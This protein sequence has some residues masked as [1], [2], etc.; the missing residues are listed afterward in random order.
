V[1]AA[2]HRVPLPVRHRL[3]RRQNPVGA[4][5]RHYRGRRAHPTRL[6]PA[7]T[8]QSPSR[9][10]GEHTSAVEAA[11]APSA[12]LRVAAGPVRGSF[13][14]VPCPPKGRASAQTPLP[15]TSSD[16][17]YLNKNLRRAHL[18]TPST[19]R[20][21]GPGRAKTPFDGRRPATGTHSPTAAP[22]PTTATHQLPWPGDQART[23]V[24]GTPES[25][26]GCTYAQAQSTRRRGRASPT[27]TKR[28]CQ[29]S[30]VGRDQ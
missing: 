22:S 10:L 11:C 6:I 19:T 17:Q 25:S 1:A 29:A 24:T 20:S 28:R 2:S 23:T 8:C 30:P 3:G 14:V 7:P 5:H 16:S 9:R 21:R 26:E 12:A 27:P 4:E 18:T 13:Q 15:T